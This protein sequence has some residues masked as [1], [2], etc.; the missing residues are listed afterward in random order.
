LAIAAG[1]ALLATGLAVAFVRERPRPAPPRGAARQAFASLARAFG[2]PGLLTVAAFLFLWNFNPF[3]SRVLQLHMTESLGLSQTFYGDCDAV[4][5]V[6]AMLGSLSYGF[7]CRRVPLAWLLHGSIVLGV[8][9]TLSYLPLAGRTSAVLASAAAGLTNATAVL[10][11]LDVAARLCPVDAAGTA[12]AL[13]MAIS[14]LGMQSSLAFGG[15]WYERLRV[16]LAS[17]DRAF[18][19]LVLIGAS[20][21]AGCW[22]LTGRLRRALEQTPGDEA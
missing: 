12:F 14:N 17:A 7:Y 21:T 3:S 15:D 4:Y 20:F 10:I 22:L 13:L 11:Q 9:S 18:Q 8:A 19:A 5:W 16:G 1:I 2:R 6:A